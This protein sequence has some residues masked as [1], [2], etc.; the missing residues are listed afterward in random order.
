MLQ[1]LIAV[2]LAVAGFNFF[3]YHHPLPG[4]GTIAYFGLMV[5]INAV[6]AVSFFSPESSKKQNYALSAIGLSVLSAA[7][8]VLRANEVDV[9]LLGLASLTLSGLGLYV[10]ALTHTQFG[11]LSELVMVPVQL[12]FNWL[13]A[14]GRMLE[15][16]PLGWKMFSGLVQSLLPSWEVKSST[17]SA[18]LRGLILTVPVVLI[19]VGL[20]GSADPIFSRYLSNIF[21]FQF[22]RFVITFP[23]RL[24]QSLVVL[25][26]ALPTVT[27][28]IRERFRSPLQNS[29]W[30]RYTVEALMVVGA[31]S[32]V[33]GAFL[34]VQFRY[35]FAAVPETQLHQFGV[36]TYSEYVRRGFSELT[37][38]ACIVYAVV[39]A[40]LLVLRQADKQ[41]QLLKKANLVLLS[42]SLIFIFSIFRRVLLYQAEHGLTR[43][44]IYGS[45]F[46]LMIIALSVV[47]ILRH[48]KDKVKEWYVYEIG[49]A[50]ATLFLVIFINVDHSIATTF[51]PTVNEEVDYVYISRLSADGAEGWVEAYQH[52]R[53]VVMDPALA[54]KTSFSDDEAR[55]IVY[56]YQTLANIRRNYETL[57]KRYGTKE[58]QTTF[59]GPD[60]QSNWPA[61]QTNLGEQQAYQLLR[62]HIAI[63]EIKEVA[64]QSWKLYDLLTP[65]Q[66]AQNYDRSSRTPLLD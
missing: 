12:V 51:K 30:G 14:G 24:I 11:A 49:I 28:A 32:V 45:L 65:Q 43:I 57:T 5:L 17:S 13:L 19:I 56:A 23:D 35:L 34:I 62:R 59:F 36:Q 4:M 21:T 22:P 9:Q 47:L 33:L 3:F 61:R 53:Q 48:L 29:A 1:K 64:P 20:L 39:G 37:L 40:S 42:E 6:I 2:T 46:L 10:F 52:A 38:V 8:S 26:I 16:L 54:N 44:R 7:F 31:V 27:L 60:Y 55:H 15:K 18:V 66:R 41:A 63:E 58:E 25:G 50:I